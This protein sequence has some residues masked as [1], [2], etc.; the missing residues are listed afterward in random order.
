MQQ[1]DTVRTPSSWVVVGLDNG[2]TCN[3]ATV[4][5]GTGRYL[6]DRLVENPSRVQEG[7]EAAVEALAEAFTNILE[8]TSTPL[9]LVRAVGLDTPG[10][11][12]ADGVISS[13]GSTNFSQVSWHGFD[14]RGALQARIGLPVIYHNDANA[15]ALYAH[16]V[17]FGAA[18]AERSSVAAIVGTGL[19]G[20]VVESGRVIGGAAGMAGELGHVQVPLDGLLEKDQPVPRCNCGFA[21]DAESIASLT[22]I[23]KNLLPYWLTRYPEHEL[24]S[25]PI[26]KAAKMLRSYGERDDPMALAVFRQQAMAIG[27]LFT[28]ASNFTD[29]HAYFLG[30]GVVEAAPAFRQ[31]FLNTVRE[32]TELRVEQ[33]AASTFALVP[34]RDMA[35]ARGAAVAALGTL[36]P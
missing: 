29:P 21:G 34:D 36:T 12:S 10:P 8:L 18:A 14:I 25:F 35:G 20:G 15:A 32:H 9:T 33:V 27:R 17:H 3:N 4:L 6:V 31:W 11:A 23:A 7:P 28:I 5:D 19:G 16:H 13:K 26:G 2:G 24:A 1:T 22:G 30:G